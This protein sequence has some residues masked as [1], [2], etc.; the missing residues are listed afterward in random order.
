V[1]ALA[2]ALLLAAACTGDLD[3]P[4]QLD[5]DRIIAVRASQPGLAPGQQA[6]LDALI[7]KKGDR[8]SVAVPEGAMVVAPTSL[9]DTLSRQGADWVVTAPS[10]DRI[11]AARSE[12]KLAAGA[13]VPLQIGVAYG[14]GS[15]LGT[16]VIEL[17]T[18]ADN[19]TLNDVMVNGADPGTSEIVFGKL[20]RLPLSV[21]ANDT[22]FD[23]TWLTSCGTMHDFDLPTAY[24]KIED[25][26]PTEGELALV[27]RDSH[28]G[29]AWR[30]WAIRAD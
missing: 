16:K 25:D 21:D 10:A 28:G 19:P 14:G 3:P 7:G 1:K 2:A 20:D 11:D 18:A 29:V 30:S 6:R 15:L 4:W 13:P 24:L 23:V 9:A 22:D 8:I 17:G 27:V 5:H 12:L 26:D